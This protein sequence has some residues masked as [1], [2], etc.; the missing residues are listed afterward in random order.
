MKKLHTIHD[1][2][3]FLVLWIG[4]SISALGSSMTNYALIIWAYQREEGT[5]SSIAMLSVCSYLPS[6]LFV[7]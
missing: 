4:Q 1:L 2:Q 3:S 5:A 6:I 7:L